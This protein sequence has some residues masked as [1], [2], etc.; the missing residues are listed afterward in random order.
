MIA[1][2]FC[3]KRPAEG[4]PL[5][6]QAVQQDVLR[7]INA[8]SNFFNQFFII[9]NVFCCFRGIREKNNQV[10]F[11]FGIDNDCERNLYAHFT[12]THVLFFPKSNVQK[13]KGKESFESKGRKYMY[14]ISDN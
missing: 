12:R 6:G 7:T 10:P 5:R 2:F 3:E 13:T 9:E 14:F 1:K 4:L 8:K 11:Y